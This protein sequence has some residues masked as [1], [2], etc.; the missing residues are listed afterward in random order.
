MPELRELAEPFH[1]EV[2]LDGVA[3]ATLSDRVSSDMFWRSYRI[4]PVGGATAIQD[5]ELW[6]QCRFT[7]RD[8]V[9]GQICTCG[10]AGGRRPFVRDGRVRLRA[11]YF[12]PAP[13]LPRA[14]LR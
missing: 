4:E 14:T 2:V 5:D 8:P 9:S 13:E 11:M 7:F 3:V 10:F 6:E 1:A 12:G